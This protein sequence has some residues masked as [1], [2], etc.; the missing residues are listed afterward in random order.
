LKLDTGYRKPNP[1]KPGKLKVTIKLLR[2][3]IVFSATM[4]G[5]IFCFNHEVHEEHEEM[6]KYFFTFVNLRALRGE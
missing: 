1:D 3:L 5:L 6:I 2:A 4:M